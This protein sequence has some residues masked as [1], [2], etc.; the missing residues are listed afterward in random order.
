M[1]NIVGDNDPNTLPG[2]TGDDTITGL[3]GNDILEGGEGNDT[4]NGGPGND[5]LNGGNGTDTATFIDSDEG[6]VGNVFGV[7]SL[8][9][10]ETDT[11]ISIENLIGSNFDDQ[12]V[13]DNQAN[14]I[15]GRGGQDVLIGQNGDDTLYGEDGDD[16]LRG[17]NDND[18]LYGGIGNDFL[19]GGEGNDLM[20]GGDGW[21]RAAFFLSLPTDAQVGAT[22]D[23]NIQGVA[24]NTGHGMDTLVSIEHVSGTALADTLTGNSGANWLWGQGGGDTIN[25]GGGDDLIEIGSIGA[26]LV[27]GGAGA[28]DTLSF[29]N[30][31]DFTSGVV[32]SLLLQGTNQAVGGGVF[33]TGFENLSGSTFN[34]TLTGDA[35]NNQLAGAEGNDTL[36]GG[37]G[38]D[39]L[40]GD[41]ITWTYSTLGGSGA[42]ITT[43]DLDTLGIGAVPGDDTLIGGEG[44]DILDGGAGND[45]LYGGLGNDTIRGGAGIDTVSY[46]DISVVNGIGTGV[47]LWR[48]ENQNRSQG[49]GGFDFITGVENVIGSQVSDTLEGDEGDNVLTGLGGND[50]LVGHGGNDTLIGGAGEDFLRGRN[51]DDVMQGGADGDFLSGGEGNDIADGGDGWDRA[52]MALIPTDAQVGATVDLNIAGP[53]NTGHG[54]DT[55]ISIEHVSGTTFADTLTG[56]AGDNWL[57]GVGG[58]DTLN[59]GEGND[60]LETGS[61]GAN[62][63]NGGGG[64]DTASF[65]NNNDFTSGVVASLLLQGQAQATTAGGSFTLTSIENLSGG[66]FNDTLTGDSGNNVLA[67][68]SGADTLDG[69]DGNDVLLGDGAI[70]MNSN[71]G[72][73]G[74]IVQNDDLAVLFNNPAYNG[75]DILRGGAGNDTL[76]GGGGDDLLLGGLGNDTIR[77]GAGIDTVSYE[78]IS[79][80]NGIGVGVYLSRP[81]NVNRSQ[82]DG[83]FDLI[84]GV[85]NVI[86][87]Q[88][89]DTLEGDGADNVLTGLGGN[90]LLIGHGGNDT[91][92]GGAG[93]DFLRGRDGDDIM[94]GGA[95]NDFLSGGAGNDTFDG[96][97]GWD[98]A[99]MFL[100]LPTD[101]QVGATVDLAIVG[102]QNTGQGMDTF[103]GVEHVSGTTFS[104]TFYGNDGANWL[105]GTGGGD[106]LDGRGGDDL[107]EAGIG[108][109]I[110]TGGDGI[111]TVRLFDNTNPPLNVVISLLLQGAAQDTGS[112]MMTLSGIEN[113][114]GTVGNDTLTGDGGA[115][116]LAG[117]QGAD[118]LV[119]G[120]GNDLL[121]GDGDIRM[122]SNQGGSGPITLIENLATFFENPTY[123]GNDSLSGGDGDDRLVGGGGD[124]LL[125]GGSGTNILDGGDGFDTATYADATSEVAV[126]LNNGVGSAQVAATDTLL[127]IERVIGSAFNDTLRG[128][129]N[130]DTLIGGAGNDVVRGEGGDDY[131]DGGADDDFVRGG[132]GADQVHGGDG[133][134]YVHGGEGDDTIDGGD[135]FDR[136]AFSL[137]VTDAQVGATVD[138]NIQGTAQNTGHGM[139]TLVSIEH[140]SGTN[141]ADTLIGNAEDNWLWGQDGD[142]TLQGGEGNDLIEV[143][144]GNHTVDGGL[145]TDTLL[146]G[147]LSETP[148]NITFSLA[149]QGSAQAFG[150]GTITASGIENLAGR[151]GDDTLTGDD[152]A[153]ILAGGAGHDTLEGGDGADQ[154]WG[155]GVFGITGIGYSGEISFEVDNAA[156]END[157]VLSGDDVLNGGDGDDRI[158]GGGG[159]DIIDGGADTDT[160]VFSGARSDYDFY[161]GKSGELQVTDLRDDSPDG[162][163]EVR[164]VEFFEFSDGVF[165]FGDVAGLSPQPE[166]DLLQ[167]TVGQA[168]SLDASLLLLNDDFAPEDYT[169][170][171]TG[172]SNAVG[173]TVQLVDGRLIIVA[174]VGGGSF[175]YTVQGEFGSSIGRV[176][177]LAVATTGGGDIV[178]AA[179]EV[180]AADLHGQGGNDVL[181]GTIETDRLVGGI[182]NDTLN[183]GLGDDIM[184]GGTQNDTYYV[185]S[186]GDLVIEAANEGDDLVISSINYTLGDNVERLTLTGT[187]VFATGNALNNILTGNDGD[188]VL[189]GR[190][191]ADQMRGG[192]GNDTY[193]VDN[194]GDA[195]T[196]TG[197]VDTVITTLN[198]YTLASATLENLTFEGR[199]DFN[200]VGNSVANVLTGGAGNDRLDGLG[201]NDIMIGGMGYDTYVVAQA[202]DVVIEV[203]GQGYDTVETSIDYTLASEVEALIGLGS[204]NLALTGN[205]L[206]NM[207]FGNSGNNVIRGGGGED[208]MYGGLG[209]DTYYFDSLSDRVNEE[210]GQ[211]DDHVISSLSY[212]LGDNVERLTII[213][214]AQY[215]GGNA[216]D[217]VLIGNDG[218]N[219]LDGQAGADTM[220]GG[221]GDDLYLVDNVGDV[222]ED[223]GGYDAVFVT[224]GAYVLTASIENLTYQ[225]QGDFNGTGNALNNFLYGGDGNDRLDGAAGNDTMSGGLG[226]DTYVVGQAG[227]VVIEQNG[228]GTDTVE[229]SINYTLVAYVENLTGTGAANL[230]LTGND[231][232]NLIIGNSGNNTIDGGFGADQMAGGLGNDTYIVD[233]AGDTITELAGGG[234]VDVVNAYVNYTLSAEIERLVLLGGAVSGT[235]NAQANTIVG[236]A[237][238][239]ILDGGAGADILQGGLGNDT[240]YVD[241]AG[242]VVT[243]SGVGIDLVYASISSFT[244]NAALENLTFN[245][246]GNF[247]GVG[248][249]LANILIGGAGNDTLNGLD[250]NDTIDGGLGADAMNGGAGNDTYVVDN[251]GDTIADSAGIDTVQTTLASYTLAAAVENLAYVGVGAF[252]GNGNALANI[253]TGGAGNDT[254]NGLVGNDT[255]YGGEGTDT[256][257]GDAGNDFLDGGLGADTMNGG[258][259]DDTYVVDDIGDLVN[260]AANAGTDT[261]RTTLASLTLVANVENLTYIGSGNFTGTGNG[262]LNTLTGGTGDDT[263]DGGVGDDKLFGG[264][265]VDNLFGG[266]GIDTLDGGA[267]ID[268]MNG[269]NG[270]DTYIVDDVADVIIETATSG[271]SD[272]VRTGLSAYTLGDHL[273]GLAYTGTGSFTGTG[274]GLANAM[275]GGSGA[276]T[277]YGMGGG[278]DI[279]AGLGADTI[280]GGDANDKLYG[281]GGDDFLYGEA[282]N[283]YFYGGAGADTLTGGAGTDYYVLNT[284]ADSGVGAA[285]R[286]VI[287]DFDALDVIDLRLI[288]ANTG[289]GGDQA[290]TFI[291]TAAFTN[292]AG[293]LRYSYDGVDTHVFGDVNGDGA[294][295]F[296]VLLNGLVTMNAGDF[297]L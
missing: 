231:G 133:N 76:D 161:Y 257:N 95:D 256:L 16:I 273:E 181:T 44:I 72:G 113:L 2:T 10:D 137:Q 126:F 17:R 136:I 48:A 143:G 59:G 199:G 66:A 220:R 271:T 222:V 141:F 28:G 167:T 110:L 173:L 105:W 9:G 259:N 251:V 39:T 79:V 240:Y 205:G 159:D 75:N 275:V 46:E 260:E 119:G 172:V 166:D 99:S 247:T 112:G 149:L 74:P 132:D 52:S 140:A 243:D 15:W 280:Y 7:Q 221:L 114:T 134:D 282:G 47:Y 270:N 130:A 123:I 170:Q 241:D 51:G 49:D 158:V 207:I 188:N 42:I 289:A 45:L 122:V 248:N 238:D 116:T 176:T 150:A 115:N 283:D 296:E 272:K 80:A 67:G 192:L 285:L 43:A 262:L 18:N 111:D 258:A 196:D 237:L 185:D 68:N 13:G 281:E 182:G 127:S 261:I 102:P 60:V 104:D 198:S 153:N 11:L 217:N 19:Q 287:T 186:S 148:T 218:A 295:D 85:E 194:V 263:L 180:L 178:S 292:T 91:L 142:D 202:G 246:V 227:D 144:T 229:T 267:G 145:D 30:N 234:A 294:A 184:E 163:D 35:G 41:G 58:G 242:D 94:Q 21:D 53:Q 233:N 193:H 20:D 249:A 208:D 157:P 29:F 274:N 224:L 101:P 8:S 71:Q 254:L 4:L 89:S 206:D 286:D 61:T 73:S 290:F 268:T 297:L 155:D 189:D 125:N 201:G 5:T 212:G 33:A 183:G 171:V 239:N 1:A 92:V 87:S 250:G 174:G 38:N 12:L 40:Y 165:T 128:S 103:I 291:G 277:F 65:F 100:S 160:A 187:A 177:V 36:I 107:L 118:T 64:T 25:G 23:L 219:V 154:L 266:E 69:G 146:F 86:G 54:M 169:H 175:D 55:F 70:R 235:G 135:G 215:A 34:D 32:F 265:G 151:F 147:V 77:G 190:E 121:L 82:G 50:L 252:T 108:V 226:D 269:G 164:N 6:V 162:F 14:V 56:D 22:V 93:E 138:L 195:I 210:A 78:D 191:G 244:L 152:G 288:D 168:S 204:A 63:L 276:D 211:G 197:G 62:V 83:G 279:R 37:Q 3:G 81:E 255:L 97:D 230:L 139:D 216:L 96:G 124:D 203:S 228:Q 223:T 213:G 88:V 293:Q 27:D 84:T 278:D 264:D 253:L 284:L 214:S 24:Q 120:G 57:W 225:G 106:T 129:I 232:N 200:G 90:D 245:G 209:N 31:N 98:R 109:N 179:P 117:A 156:A 236:N 26:S 131:V